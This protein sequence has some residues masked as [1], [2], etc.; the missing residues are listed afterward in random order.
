MTCATKL[1][2]PRY[3]CKRRCMRYTECYSKHVQAEPKQM[4]VY[5]YIDLL[6]S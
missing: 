6:G 4:K 2:H 1:E 5:E 3:D